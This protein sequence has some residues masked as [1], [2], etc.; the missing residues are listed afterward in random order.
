ME[1]A[2]E[3]RQALSKAAAV[4][5]NVARSNYDWELI[6]RGFAEYLKSRYE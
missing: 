2:Y 6:G 1:V 4:A 5:P 3:N